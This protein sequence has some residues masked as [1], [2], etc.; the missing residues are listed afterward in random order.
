MIRVLG[1]D[2]RQSNIDTRGTTMASGIGDRLA[3][4]PKDGGLQQRRES[5]ELHAM[6]EIE[7]DVSRASSSLTRYS[8]ASMIPISSMII[9]R[10]SLISRRPS[11][12]ARAIR[13]TAVSSRFWMRG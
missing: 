4:D 7:L 3:D 13:E 10:S 11:L 2:L 12:I 8:M 9:G 6:R 5:I 1:A